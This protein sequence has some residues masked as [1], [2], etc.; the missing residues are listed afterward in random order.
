MRKSEETC[1]ADKSEEKN[2]IIVASN[3]DIYINLCAY[4]LCKRTEEK[5][6]L[7]DVGKREK[8]IRRL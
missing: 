3:V 8:N 7:S 6:S 4:A 1:K 2:E 5:K